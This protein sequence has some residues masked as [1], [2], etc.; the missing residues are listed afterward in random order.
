MEIGRNKIMVNKVFLMGR[1]T[2]DPETSN[3]KDGATRTQFYIAVERPYQSQNQADY[4]P[5]VCWDKVAQNVA[6][7]CFKGRMVHVEGRVQTRAY[8]ENGVKKW[9]IGIVAERVSFIGDKSRTDNGR[10]N[11]SQDIETESIQIKEENIQF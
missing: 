2:K 8:N 4:V 7:Y 11:V 9:I 1:L 10:E 6:K 5:I 3:T